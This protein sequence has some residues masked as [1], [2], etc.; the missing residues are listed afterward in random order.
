MQ[1]DLRDSS[2]STAPSRAVPARGADAR[3]R[4]SGALFPDAPVHTLVD[5][6]PDDYRRR[7][8]PRDIHPSFL[9]RL[10][11]A[12]K[13]FRRYLPLFPT[14]I[15]SLDVRHYDI[16]VSTSHAVA[17]GAR[18]RPG[19][20]HVCYCFSPMRYA[21]DL[22]EQ[23][24]AQVGFD[25]GVKSAITRRML[26]RLAAWDLA[27]SGRVQHFVGISDHI[28]DRIRRCYGRDADVIYPPVTIPRDVP[29]VPRED[30]LYVTVSRLVPYKRIDVIA[31]AFRGLPGRRLVV[32]GEGPER[33]RVQSAAGGNVVLAGQLGD[34]ERDALLARAQAFM[35]AAE[36]DFG[37]APIEAQAFGTPV[38]GFRKGGL[39]ETVAGLEHDAPTGV[40]FDAQTPEAIAHAVQQFEAHRD[41][42]TSAAC[43]SNA[44]RFSAERFRREFGDY[45]NERYRAFAGRLST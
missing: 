17:K 23:Y 30:G 35:F 31:E 13:S 21:W 33:A 9:Q 19:Q 15:E 8:G 41:R 39:V 3:D 42:I 34:A 18:T 25:T 37:I 10:P 11:F 43:R 38:I 29:A 36:E 6:F 22:R 16:V 40:L 14:A 27:S 32:V 12:R 7:L 45:V 2:R 44:E 26:D 1:A 24:L 4:P 20:L 5:F 28:A